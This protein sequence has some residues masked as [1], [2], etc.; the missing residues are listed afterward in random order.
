MKTYGMELILDLHGCNPATFNRKCIKAYFKALCDQ[1]NM[2]RE[3][4]VW[5]DYHGQPEEYKTSPPHL[6][7]VTAVQFITTS[8]VTIHTLETLKRV[9]LNI[10]ACGV[11]DA[12]V[13]TELSVGW[14]GGKVI[15][16]HVIERL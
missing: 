4:L 9:Y 6:R 10:F 12:D 5:W 2:V 8:N 1:I 16:K 13:A 11:F 7:G 3:K 15:S 14:F